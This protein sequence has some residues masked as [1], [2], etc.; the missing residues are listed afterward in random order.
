VISQPQVEEMIGA[1]RL[2]FAPKDFE[3]LANILLMCSGEVMVGNNQDSI[4]D[5]MLIRSDSSESMIDFIQIQQLE[6]SVDVLS[7]S[8][9]QKYQTISIVGGGETIVKVGS[10]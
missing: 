1:L 8:G 9:G 4:A 5:Q 6:N 10:K 7:D 3:Q 2:V